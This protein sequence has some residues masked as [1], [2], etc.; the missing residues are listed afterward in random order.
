MKPGLLLAT[1]VVT[2]ALLSAC[3]QADGTS[4]PAPDETPTPGVQMTEV[5]DSAD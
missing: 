2:L 5:P 4:T 1:L 3:T